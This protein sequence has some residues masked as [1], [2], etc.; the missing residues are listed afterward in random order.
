[1]VLLSLL[2]CSEANIKYDREI[3][4]YKFEKAPKKIALGVV[5][6][7]DSR[8][9]LDRLGID[10]NKENRTI[11][12]S[13]T[14]MA[15]EMLLSHGAFSSVS[16]ISGFELPEFYDPNALEKFKKTY[17]VDYVLGGEIVE[18]KLVKVDKR[19]S[20]G[21]KTKVF[22]SF[23]IVP[24]SYYYVARVKLR[25]KLV[26]LTDGKVVWQGEGKSYFIQG[27]KF[28]KSENVFIAS[29]HNALGEMLSKMSKVFSLDVKEIE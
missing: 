26:S 14:K 29:I 13:V 18:A 21:Y 19:S 15:E 6:F 10:E 25:G 20:L 7:S 3:K 2:G 9:E 12:K 16:I 28:Y 5:Y 24:T 1:M 27:T 8:S 22:L 4:T 23:G 11:R 17:D